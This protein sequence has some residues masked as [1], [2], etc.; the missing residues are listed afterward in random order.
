MPNIGNVTLDAS[1]GTQASWP[2]HVQVA[3]FVTLTSGHG[4]ISISFWR[5]LARERSDKWL[6]QV[7][8]ILQLRQPVH[9]TILKPA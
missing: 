9:H 7:I 1:L 3:F 5:L 6:D 2:L 4:N 8:A